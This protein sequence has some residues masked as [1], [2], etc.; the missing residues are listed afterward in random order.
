[1]KAPSAPR[2]SSTDCPLLAISGIFSVLWS[3]V[4]RDLTLLRPEVSDAEVS[5]FGYLAIAIVLISRVRGDTSVSAE[6]A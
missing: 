5:A 6:P 4:A 3:A 2:S 1:M